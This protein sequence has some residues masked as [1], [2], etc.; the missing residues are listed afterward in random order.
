MGCAWPEFS[1][2]AIAPF[3]LPSAILIF[4]VKSAFTL[5]SNRIIPVI[6]CLDAKW[7][8]RPGGITCYQ[9]ELDWQTTPIESGWIANNCLLTSKETPVS[10]IVFPWRRAMQEAVWSKNLVLGDT[11]KY[12]K[13]PQSSSAP[14]QDLTHV[15]PVCCLSARSGLSRGGMYLFKVFRTLVVPEVINL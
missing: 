12:L 9:G 7:L 14:G 15:I 4:S 2:N 5:W 6:S 13:P 1:D 3:S 10:Q 8:D 11:D